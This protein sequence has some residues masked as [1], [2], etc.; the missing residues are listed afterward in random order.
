[1]IIL[2]QSSAHYNTGA[3]SMITFASFSSSS[4]LQTSWPSSWCSLVLYCSKTHQW[5]RCKCFGSILSWIRLLLLHWQQSLLERKSCLD[6]R[7]TRVPRF[8]QMWCGETWSGMLSFKLWSWY[9]WF[10]W[11][12]PR[13][14]WYTI[15][16]YIAYKRAA[17]R[18]LAK[19]S[20]HFMPMTVTIA[21]R[22]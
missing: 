8:W 12:Q 20:T 15:I 21:K 7:N 9:S 2:P 4:W 3:M 1:M 22:Q 13:I 17:S 10:S 14:G 16:K 11:A 5:T 19:Y 6:I 18:V